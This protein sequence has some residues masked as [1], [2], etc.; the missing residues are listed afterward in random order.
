MK[1][2]VVLKTDGLYYVQRKRPPYWVLLIFEPWEDFYWPGTANHRLAVQNCQ[3]QIKGQSRPKV[4]RTI[5]P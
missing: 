3:D 4:I 1:Y 5:Y 2:R